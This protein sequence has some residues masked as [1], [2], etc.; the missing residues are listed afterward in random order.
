PVAVPTQSCPEAQPCPELPE[1]VA[2]PFEELWK[3]SP[4]ADAEAEAFV[5]WDEENPAE[6]PAN[7]ATCHS[8]TGFLDFVGADGSEAFKVDANAAIGT[9]VSCETCH[10]DATLALDKVVFPSGVEMTGLGREAVCMT[11]H[12]GRASKVQVDAAIEKVAVAD[13]DTVS[14]DLGFTNIHYFAAAVSR[15]GTEVKGGYEYEGKVYDPE[16]AHVDGV[17][18]CT[19]CHNSH[20]LEVKVE[21]CSGCHGITTVEEL[22]DVREPSSFMDYD[23]DDDL[24]EGVY[25]EVV[26]LQEML[27]SAI[28]TYATEVAGAPIVYNAAAHPYFFADTNAN[29]AADEGE[30][31]Y[32]NWTPRL[33][34]AAYN[35]QV[36]QKDPGG[37][38]HGG[39]Y[40]IQLMYD[41]IEDLNISLDTPVDLTTAHRD[42]AGHFAASTEA[43]RHWD[44]EGEVPG[45]CAKCHQGEGLPQFIKNNTNIAM[46]P[47]SGLY[48]ETWPAVYALETV[49]FPSGA[50]IGFADKPEANLCLNCHQ[51]RESTASVNRTIGQLGDDETSEALRFRNVHYFAAGATLFGTD[52]KGVYEYE[53]KTYVGQFA[54]VANFTT[55]VDCHNVH[56]LSVQTATCNGCHGSTDPTTIRGTSHTDVDYDGDGDVTEGIAGEL[57]T[58]AE[59]L[60][61]GLVA[62]AAADGTPLTYDSHAYPY[63][64][65]DANTNNAVDEG[66]AGY[67]TWTPR[68]L[69][70]AYNYQYFQKDPGAYAHN[71]V[72]MLQVLF[73]A[74]EDIGGSTTG[75]TRPT[76]PAP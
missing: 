34:K 48:C 37:Y 44:A 54:H 42:D 14:P 21:V 55:C 27:L 51:G 12:Q 75:M 8:S 40:L 25:Y 59:K 19:D 36:T 32:V 67:A 69:K 26:G 46:E 68:L 66:E 15:F 11:C 2:A 41:S 56:E 38:A 58:M 47:T 43:W 53:G 4:H 70:A 20:S 35:Y 10:T 3:N 1:T 63:F 22:R 60:Y 65:A 52:A 9:V 6:V 72:Y 61:E 73:D 30:E 18:T 62:K 39:K 76:T 28:T 23:G 7:C 13:V 5:H 31:K 64:F 16:F 45:S 57:E 33:L 74:I 50:S 49:T 17:E 29:G 71:G 24:E